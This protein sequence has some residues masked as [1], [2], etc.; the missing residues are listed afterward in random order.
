MPG[1]SASSSPS[2]ASTMPASL[3]STAR[4]MGS[5]HLHVTDQTL[6]EV[7]LAVE[8]EPLLRELQLMQQEHEHDADQE[9][10]QRG[11]ECHTQPLGDARDVAGD[12]LVSLTECV[13]DAADCADEADGRDR[14]GDVAQHRK[15]RVEPIRLATA[16]A[17]RCLGYVLH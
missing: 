5:P 17:A 4:V 16:H 13:A 8:H 9:R 11:V 2:A 1:S 3:I 6:V 12:G 7:R 14:P 10:D 15:L